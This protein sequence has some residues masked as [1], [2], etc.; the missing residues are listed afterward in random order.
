MFDL[1]KLLDTFLEVVISAIVWAIIYAIITPR[2]KGWNDNL[3][4]GFISTLLVFYT[5]GMIELYLKSD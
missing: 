5:R 2:K 1:K 4:R 3:R